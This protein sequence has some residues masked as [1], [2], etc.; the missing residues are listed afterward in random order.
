MSANLA[1]ARFKMLLRFTQN[2]PVFVQLQCGR[3]GL[4]WLPTHLLTRRHPSQRFFL[5]C[6]IKGRNF[7]A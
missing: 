3:R 4:T 6:Q 7:R 5:N 1:L 2:H